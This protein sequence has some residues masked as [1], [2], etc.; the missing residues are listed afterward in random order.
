MNFVIGD[1]ESISLDRQFDIITLIDSLRCI[2]KLDLVLKSAQNAM[3]QDSYFIIADLFD[4]VGDFES[5]ISDQFE[6]CAKENAT[7][8]VRLAT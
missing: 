1:V 3:H 4:D 2:T 6:I 8:N 7:Y 5:K